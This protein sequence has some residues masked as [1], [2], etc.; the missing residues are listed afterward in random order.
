M[1]H[2]DHYFFD[3][4]LSRGIYDSIECWD[5]IFS[6][7]KRESFLANIFG[8]QEVFKGHSFI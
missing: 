4:M 3:S 5:G 1:G 6:P 8:V 2:A 7:F